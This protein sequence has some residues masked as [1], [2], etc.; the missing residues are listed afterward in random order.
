VSEQ[1]Y[2]VEEER[3]TSLRGRSA[4]WLSVLGGLIVVA[5]SWFLFLQPALFGEDEFQPV[6]ATTESDVDAEVN[7]SATDQLTPVALPMVTYEV[8]LS[9]DP[10]DPVVEPEQEVVPVD[11]TDPNAP[12]ADPNA[13]PADPNA[14][15]ADPNA[16]PADPNA[17]PLEPGVPVLVPGEPA[18]S[19]TGEVVCAGQ[20]V[21]LMDV[22]STGEEP[23][24]IIQIGATVY[25]VT[26]GMRFA[27]GFVARSIDGSCVSLLYG[28][29][30]FQLCEGERVMK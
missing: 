14:P 6:A 23:I 28:D 13:P 16:P 30:A 9:R 29:E 1:T 24:A 10:F 5:L 7:Q 18:C 8:F 15:P 20:V 22:V 25:E 21:T 17:P 12:P 4:L 3:R 26:V 19:G 11:G 27:E 2:A